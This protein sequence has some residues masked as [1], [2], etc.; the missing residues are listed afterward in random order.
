MKNRRG[1]MALI[2]AGIAF[3]IPQTPAADPV[4]GVTTVLGPLGPTAE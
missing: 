3:A 1:T 2:L 4:A